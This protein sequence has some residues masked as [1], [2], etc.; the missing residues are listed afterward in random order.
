MRPKKYLERIFSLVAKESGNFFNVAAGVLLKPRAD[1]IT[2]VVISRKRFRHDT[3]AFEIIER[4]QHFLADELFRFSKDFG[5]EN[6]KD[7]YKLSLLSEN[8][9]K[10]INVNLALGELK[11]TLNGFSR[12]HKSFVFKMLEAESGYFVGY[13][14]PHPKDNYSR[15]FIDRGDV[16][17]SYFDI[18]YHDEYLCEIIFTH[19]NEKHFDLAKNMNDGFKNSGSSVDNFYS[20]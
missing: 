2:G 18:N 14:P 6:K 19:L 20:N 8:Y 15:T 10:S 4:L 11:K 3:L 16:S 5:I 12:F 17:K 13:L 7:I 9:H 1:P